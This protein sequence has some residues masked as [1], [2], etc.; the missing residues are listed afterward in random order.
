MATVYS[1]QDL[2][3]RRQVAIKILKP[4]L[5]S[6]LGAERFLQEI[7]TS[8]SLRHPHILPL[9][10]SGQAGEALFYVM[11]LVTGESLR[12]RLLRERQLPIEEALQ[13]AR[14]VAGAL[15]YAHSRG[16]IHRDIKPENIL[17]ESGHAVV[18][19]F[20]IARV[21]NA[22]RGSTLTQ[23]GTS[24]GTPQYMSPEQ[25]AGEQDLDGRSDLY[26]LACTLYEMLAGQPP[27]TGPTVERLYYQQLMETPPAITRFRSPIPVHVVAAL[28]RALAKSRFDRYESAAAF[29]T[30]LTAPS[31]PADGIRSVAVLP[32]LNMSTDPENEYFADGIT[33]DVIAQLSKV[34]A[35]KVVSRTSVMPFKKR[36]LGLRDIASTLEV[37][38]LLDGS[39]RRA[40]NRV[41]IVAQLVDA[42]TD[43]QLW[44]ETYDRDLT[45]IF[46]I[47]SEVALRIAGALRAEL[48]ADEQGRIGRTP[49]SNVR[50]YHEYLY[51]RQA[52]LKFTSEGL[53]RSI[54]HFHRAIEFDPGFAKAWSQIA[55][56][57][58]ELSG[59]GEIRAEEAF[60]SAKTAVTRALE[61][62]S[63]LSEAHCTVG[64]I[65][66][67]FD[68]QWAEAE[69]AFKR[70]IEL[71]PS[72]S[73]AWDL[74]G[75][76]CSALRR[77]DEALQLV[78]HAQELDPL[79]HR[80]DIATEF[81]R[82]GRHDEA[83]D[84]AKRAVEL[85]AED[86]RGHCTLGWA[87]INHGQ[88]D[89]GLSEI[90]KAVSLSP[91]SMLWLGQL[92]QAYGLTGRTDQAVEIL[93][94]L[95]E[96]ARTRFVAPYHLAYV[97]TGLGRLDDAIDCL[98]Q[99]FEQRAGSV[100]GVK[101][102]FLFAPLRDHPRF[103]ALLRK[104]NL[105]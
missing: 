79:T 6:A 17:L 76:L 57:Y 43:Q 9:F 31:G 94:Q 45:D 104:M 35:L 75:R 101:G 24:L 62:D 71:S 40:G 20:G 39:V 21:A 99:A 50:A 85:A 95:T 28:R 98:E 33:E 63:E 12:S 32:F 96:A 87:L 59:I 83:L 73:D 72:N 67:V 2:R 61:L 44:S 29:A 37:G 69:A 41:R 38:T 100:Y 23:A 7:E 93:A 91:R 66:T 58:T 1:A 105:A 10:D 92:G 8:A 42:S 103:V 46:A 16:V 18:A 78:Q 60:A 36:E 77:H 26:S 34:K 11:P 13:I 25:V 64:F 80:V 14:E 74:Y 27:F 70:A 86:S 56:A 82:A 102:S 5:A 97:Y 4:D 54:E 48:S 90:R 3:H 88:I 65:R 89:E 52:F 81:I 30:A 51:G 22:A 15:G 84:A 49:T 55:M 53:H 68:F 19:D 47:Q